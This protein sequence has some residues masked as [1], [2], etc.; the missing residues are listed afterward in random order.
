MMIQQILPPQK[1]LLLHII[2]TSEMSL[3][4]NLCSFQDIPGAENGA[5]TQACSN[6]FQ[7]RAEDTCK[8]R[9]SFL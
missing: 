4:R 6:I 8:R 5:K 3:S 1:P 7:E 9:L 2:H